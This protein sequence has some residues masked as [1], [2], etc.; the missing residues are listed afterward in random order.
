MTT[1]NPNLRD[2]VTRVNQIADAVVEVSRTFKDLKNGR[3]N[4]KAVMI[5][6]SHQTGLS[7]AVIKKV[8]AGLEDLEKTYVKK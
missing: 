7:Q 3:L 6:L 5:L 2:A 8:F 4:D 1:A